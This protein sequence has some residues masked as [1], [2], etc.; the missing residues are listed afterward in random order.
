MATGVTTMK[1]TYDPEVG[2]LGILFR[3]VAVE[4]CDDR[5]RAF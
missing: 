4:E 1:I 5:D 2:V 3:D